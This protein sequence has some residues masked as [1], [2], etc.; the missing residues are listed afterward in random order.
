M[1][2]RWM[3]RLWAVQSQASIARA[4][5]QQIQTKPDLRLRSAN[6]VGHDRAAGAEWLVRADGRIP[7]GLVLDLGIELG[8]DQHDDGREPQPNHETDDRAERAVGRI[9]VGEIGEVPG[10]QKTTRQSRSA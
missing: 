9:V 1:N 2:R 5:R 8:A 4:F 10:E 7:R 3:N 6:R